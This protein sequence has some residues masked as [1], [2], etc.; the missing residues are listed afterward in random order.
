[1]CAAQLDELPEN[2]QTPETKPSGGNLVPALIAIVLA[3]A[4]TVGAMF[5]NSDE[6]A[7]GNNQTSNH[8]GRTT[9]RHGAIWGRKILRVNQPYHQPGWS[10]KIQIH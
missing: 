2:N 5:F 4:L 3:P 9:L 6:Q 1:M 10:D 7:R 8:R